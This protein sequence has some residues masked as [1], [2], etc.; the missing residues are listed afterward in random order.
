MN[1]QLYVKKNSITECYFSN[2]DLPSELKEGQIL[3]KVDTVALTANNVTYAVTGYMLKYWDFFPTGEA[4]WGI[5][6]V[7]GFADVIQSE[8]DEVPVGQRLYGYWPMGSF[9]VMDPVRITGAGLRDGAEH[10]SELN[11]IYNSY[12]RVPSALADQEAYHSLLRPMFSTSFL[13]DDYLWESTPSA[14]T[15]IV[16]SASSKTGYGTAF[17]LNKNKADRGDYEIVG[18]TSAGN[19][20]YVKGLGLYDTVLAYDD[21]ASLPNKDAAA[22]YADFSGNAQLRHDIHHHYQDN[23]AQDVVIGVTDWTNQGPA[24]GLPGARA[25]MFFAPSQ[26]QKRQKEW[27]TAEFGQ[28]LLADLSAFIEFAADQIDVVNVSGEKEIAELWSKMVK[29]KFDPRTGYIL[30]F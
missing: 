6:P 26:M 11:A 30:S 16:S 20:D 25:E 27:G 28:R 18:L 2:D 24:K 8:H 3:C 23:M 15:F 29:G 17:L 22:V 14:K 5:V 7:W 10:R 9:L 13:L 21:I 4:D 1:N 19:V 12:M